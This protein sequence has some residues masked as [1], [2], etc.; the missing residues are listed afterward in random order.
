M[1]RAPRARISTM[2]RG[3]Q[4][5]KPQSPVRFWVVPPSVPVLKDSGRKTRDFLGFSSFFAVFLTFSKFELK[6]K[7]KDAKRRFRPTARNRTGGMLFQGGFKRVFLSENRPFFVFH[8]KTLLNFCVLERR[9]FGSPTYIKKKT[10]TAAT[11]CIIP[12]ENANCSGVVAIRTKYARGPP[13]PQT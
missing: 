12:K 6:Q 2:R 7:Q 8:K 13:L 5:A 4:P 3:G 9:C 11:A 10:A 1:K